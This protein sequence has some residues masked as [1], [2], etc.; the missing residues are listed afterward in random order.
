MKKPLLL[1]LSISLVI[2]MLLINAFFKPKP[3][4][5]DVKQ[6]SE[7]MYNTYWWQGKYPPNFDLLLMDGTRFRLSEQ[8]GKK[9]V[10]LN[11]FTTWCEP[12]REETPELSAYYSKQTVEYLTFIGINVNEKPD[13]VKQYLSDL[14]PSFPVGIDNNSIISD[15]FNVKSYPTTIVIG[16]D[17]K[18]AL[19]EVGGIANAEVVF[20]PIIAAN[21]DNIRKHLV[22]D[23]TAYFREFANQPKPITP[24]TEVEKAKIQMAGDALKFAERMHCPSCGKSLVKC[25]CNFCD[26]VKLKLKTMDFKDKKDEQ[27][28]KDLFL[29]GEQQ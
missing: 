12:C 17:G 5:K 23:S 19:Y 18:I 6:L 15:Q 3:E 24:D 1:S 11:F 10:I 21:R 20:D 14:R 28:L 4:E 25:T 7:Y 22:I 27:I 26:D 16:L 29:T 9:V 8:I 13:L 2:C